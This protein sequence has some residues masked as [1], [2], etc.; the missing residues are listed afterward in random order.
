MRVFPLQS[1]DFLLIYQN[2][3][4]KTTVIMMMLL[5]PSVFRRSLQNANW[6]A[7]QRKWMSSAQDPED[8][9]T[10]RPIPKKG[11]LLKPQGKG[12]NEDMTALLRA[13][14]AKDGATPAEL[15]TVRILPKYRFKYER[16]DEKLPT[17][18]G[19]WTKEE[20]D[21]LKDMR[22]DYIHPRVIADRLGRKASSVVDKLISLSDYFKECNNAGRFDGPQSLP[23]ELE[24]A[25]LRSGLQSIWEGLMKTNM[26]EMWDEVLMAHDPTHWQS[27]I[28]E[29][30]PRAVVSILASIQPPHLA[31]LE[32]LTWSV[33]SS[34]GVFAWILKPE[35]G[36]FHF[37][38]ECYVYI[39]SATHCGTGL[40]DR[41]AKLQSRPYR[42]DDS[43]IKSINFHRLDRRGKFVTLLEVPFADDSTE[44][45]K[46]VRTQVALARAVLVIWLG[47]VTKQS[48][49]AITGLV[50]WDVETINYLGLSSHNGL[51]RNIRAPKLLKQDK[52]SVAPVGLAT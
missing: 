9:V 7:L 41:K 1:N 35:K 25:L 32:S 38:N 19:R 24:R 51:W 4:R 46:R 2:T 12:E 33:T 18:Q 14:L 49:K 40:A 31:R 34:A 23:P 45:I 27:T 39:G 11:R 20:T 16:K 30:L 10:E 36:S 47:A 6:C 5:K 37:D 48:R 3:T 21:I 42:G 15:K 13:Q 43:I 22:R 50:P 17:I 29:T 44:E 28:A 26:T 8:E 52:L